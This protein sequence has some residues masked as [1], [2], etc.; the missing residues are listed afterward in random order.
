[1]EE[2][3]VSGQNMCA[4]N[5]RLSDN[6]MNTHLQLRNKHVEYPW[7]WCNTMSKSNRR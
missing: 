1:M 5:Y 6:L 2:W 4:L 7:R 3:I